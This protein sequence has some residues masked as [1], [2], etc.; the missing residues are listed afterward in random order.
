MITMVVRTYTERGFSAALTQ[1]VSRQALGPLLLA[2]GITLLREC[3]P[4]SHLL[5]DLYL[6]GQT[7]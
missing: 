7:E 2:I 4:I 5:A 1:M 6:V 3:G